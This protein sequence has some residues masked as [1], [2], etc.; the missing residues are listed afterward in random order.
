M[1]VKSAYLD[2]NFLVDALAPGRPQSEEAFQVLCSIG[3]KELIGFIM[4]NQL[5]DFYYIC[6]KC[7]MSDADRRENVGVLL[8]ICQLFEPDRE[9]LRTALDSD[10]PDFED[11][12][13]RAAAEAVGADCIVSRDSKA[14][15]ASSVPKFEPKDLAG[16]L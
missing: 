9:T 1:S 2:T 15:S 11:G 10:E 4:F 7:G 5:V 3:R 16:M 13:I 8:Y 6:R 14:F 12:L